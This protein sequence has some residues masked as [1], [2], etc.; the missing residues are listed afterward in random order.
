[1]AKYTANIHCIVRN[2]LASQQS[3]M[4]GPGYRTKL[5]QDIKPNLLH[6]RPRAVTFMALGENYGKGLVS[7]SGSTNISYTQ[8]LL[9]SAD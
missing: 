5:I 2:E 8:V 9:A 3:G 4:G 7:I 1:M 6:M